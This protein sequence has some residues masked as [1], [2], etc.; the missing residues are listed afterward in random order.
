MKT[1]VCDLEITLDFIGGKWKPL[2]IYFLIKGPKRT[3]EL[4]TLLQSISQK[5]LIQSLKELEHDK[6]I[7]RKVYNQRPPK[8]EYSITEIGQTL[9]PMLRALCAWGKD[10]SQKTLENES[11]K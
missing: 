10:Y 4:K 8:V 6:L 5:M 1:Y 2:I 7:S 11:L 3:G 9:E